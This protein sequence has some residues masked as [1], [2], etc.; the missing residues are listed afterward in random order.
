MAIQESVP[1]LATGG[2]TRAS[3]RRFT[4]EYKTGIVQEAERCRASGEIGSLLRREGLFSSQLTEWRKR[5]RAG[6]RRALSAKRG[7]KQRSA[8]KTEIERLQ[9]DNETL[10][11]KLDHAEQLIGLQKK[12]AELLGA[13]PPEASGESK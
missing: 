7:P 13:P 11:R 4:V 12:L 10:R 8:A 9:R 3:R 5:Y 1:P 2:S 6:A